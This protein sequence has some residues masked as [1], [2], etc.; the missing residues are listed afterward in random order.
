MNEDEKE[1]IKKEK[2][3][4]LEKISKKVLNIYGTDED[5][6]KLKIEKAEWTEER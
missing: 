2:L 3:E 6:K 5:N 4:K 1:K